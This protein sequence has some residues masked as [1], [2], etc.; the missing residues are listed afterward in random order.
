MHVWYRAVCTG[1]KTISYMDD[2]AAQ[3]CC[4]NRAM[5]VLLT[6]AGLGLGAALALS[7]AVLREDYHESGMACRGLRRSGSGRW[8]RGWCASSRPL[9][10]LLIAKRLL[11]HPTPE[12]AGANIVHVRNGGY[13]G[14]AQQALSEQI[15]FECQ[16]EMPL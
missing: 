9:S 13:R 2:G 6:S 11:T 3:L 5:A 16:T 1:T 7:T 14:I 10:L 8:W 12:H 15:A 4:I